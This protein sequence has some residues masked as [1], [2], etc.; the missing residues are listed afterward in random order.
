MSRLDDIARKRERLVARAAEQRRAIGE[1]LDGL[2]GVLSVAD[3]AFTLG[4]WARGHPAVLAIAT[5]GLVALR[6]KLGLRWVVRALSLWRTGRFALDLLKTL[7]A[8][9]AARA[10]QTGGQS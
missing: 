3:R 10:G 7:A 8:M 2:Q 9:R 6:P 4:K 5:T 1:S